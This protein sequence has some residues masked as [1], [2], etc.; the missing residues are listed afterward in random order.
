MATVDDNLHAMLVGPCPAVLTT[1]RSDGSAL[2]SPVWVGVD[3]E[4]IEIVMTERDGKVRNLQRDPRCLLV[5]FESVPP[6][7][8]VEV[9]ADAGIDTG[10]RAAEVRHGIARRYLGHEAG[11]RFTAARAQTPSVV[12]RLPTSA[13]R[14]WDL[15][16][17]VD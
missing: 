14:A 12:V 7:R 16:S 13:A 17:I 1:Y 10:T 4:Y 15:S 6:F 2:T 8:G 9:R 5:L 11:D 3:G